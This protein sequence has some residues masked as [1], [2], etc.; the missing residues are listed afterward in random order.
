MIS[1]TA[2]SLASNQPSIGESSAASVWRGS[3]GRSLCGRGSAPIET[4]RNSLGL[5]GVNAFR[6]GAFIGAFIIAAVT[7]GR[8]RNLRQ[9]D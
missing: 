6:Q 8:I 3:I 7:F 5:L 4:I 9:S 2:S 1:P